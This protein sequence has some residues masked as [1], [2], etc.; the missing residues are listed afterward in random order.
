VRST[1][2]LTVADVARLLRGAAVEAPT[3][4]EALVDVSVTG[5]ALVLGDP[6]EGHVALVTARR[7]VEV[8]VRVR[9]RPRIGHRGPSE[10]QY[11]GDEPASEVAPKLFP[12]TPSKPSVAD[13]ERE[14]DHEELEAELVAAVSVPL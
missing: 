13:R 10:Q 1:E 14:R 6:A 2:V 5:E 12:H 3:L 7:V 4:S 8:G 9:E 11:A